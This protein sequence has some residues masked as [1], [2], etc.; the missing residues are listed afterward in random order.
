M[1]PFYAGFHSITTGKANCPGIFLT[2]VLWDRSQPKRWT[3]TA[4]RE[5]TLDGVTSSART[6]V[7]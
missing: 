5:E 1:K 3:V 7:I 2:G 4:K 6:P